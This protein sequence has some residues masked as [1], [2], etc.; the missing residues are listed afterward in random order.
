MK[1]AQQ[2]WF[3]AAVVILAA[4][5]IHAVLP[6][7]TDI[8]WLCS[9]CR[10]LL[11]G[12]VLYRD[13]VETNPP[14]AVW[15]YLPAVW[16][17]HVTGVAA[18]TVFVTM[19]LLVGAGS[20]LG[21]ARLAG[22]GIGGRWVVL[23]IV[24]IM[25][26]SAFAEREHIAVI[27][28][29]PVLGLAIRRAKGEAV[30]LWAAVLCGVLAG[31]APM[32]KPHFALGLA[33]AFGA[34]AYVR[35]DWRLLL[36]PEIV[37]AGTLS[38][39]YA[40]SV[41]LFMPAYSHDV[42]PLLLDVY[43]PMRKPFWN[44]LTS[45]QVLTWAMS[46]GA[47]WYLL[48]RFDA[49]ATVLLAASFGFLIG[50]VDQGR[51]WAYHALPMVATLMLAVWIT[52]WPTIAAGQPETRMRAIV[53]CFAA[54]VNIAGYSIFTYPAQG[55]VPTIRTV[56]AHPSV[57]AI[58]ADQA[59]GHPIATRIHGSWIGTY[60]SRWITANSMALYSSTDDP[61]KQKRLVGWMAFDR[62]ATNRDLARRPDIVLV[63]LGPYNW[64]RWISADPE[65]ARLMTDYVLVATDEM[66]PQ[67][68][69]TYE[70]VQAWVRR[71][72]VK[73]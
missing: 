62:A 45:T 37:V 4:A 56:V 68:R 9:V 54:L 14:M 26:L 66:T 27:L 65:T 71:D 70:G 47:L 29:L 58:T 57:M 23:F 61:E 32:I 41:Y 72:L 25:P 69:K 34:A 38:V 39:V 1:Y 28:M 63:G 8:Y 64:P 3:Q 12:A 48:R 36:A 16:V 33:A 49:Y 20:T 55:V 5:L 35:R 50:F 60:S 15:L 59:P 43:R 46:V 22:L 21:F 42:L 2:P 24:L 44:Q 13:I 31:L 53:A 18:E 17:E 67:K 7:D 19:V 52:A 30:A 10:R 40:A 6:L 11:G 51:G 73:P